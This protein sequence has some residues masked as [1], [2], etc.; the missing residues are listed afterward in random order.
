MLSLA[1]K[2]ITVLAIVML[3]AGLGLLLFPPIS[4][5]AGTLIANSE[6]DKFNT[7][8]ENIIDDGTTYNEA[9]ESGRIDSDGYLDDNGTKCDSPVLFKADLDRLYKD[10]IAYNEQLKTSQYELLRNDTYAQSALNL[11]DYGIND[12]IY[13]YVTA[14]TIDMKLPIYLGASNAN[15]SY[16]AAHMSATSLPIGGESTNAVLAGHT[17]Y[18]GRIFFDNLRNL[19][20]GDKVT[21]KNYWNTLE[22]KVTETKINKPDESQDVYINDN[23]DLLTMFTCIDNGNGGFDRYYVICE[24]VK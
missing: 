15:M 14:D 6:V 18:I 23:R 16:G 9:L 22:Y 1:K 4:N 13:G 20:I 21:I 7:Q 19:N 24:R 17:G 5:Y 3:V 11:S 10:S 12:D 2:V 8:L